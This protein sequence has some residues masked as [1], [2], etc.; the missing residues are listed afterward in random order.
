METVLINNSY[1]YGRWAHSP[2]APT[3]PLGRKQAGLSRLW[4]QPGGPCQP[5]R[6]R[7]GARAICPF[8]PRRKM[9]TPHQPQS[10]LC[11][12]QD[13]RPSAP[14]PCPPM[15]GATVPGDKRHQQPWVP[16]WTWDLGAEAS[17]VPH[18]RSVTSRWG[19]CPTPG[20]L[21]RG[22]PD[23]W[24]PQQQVVS[25]EGAGQD[26]GGCRRVGGANSPGPPCGGRT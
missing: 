5:A 6:G 7:E 19:W 20:P 12:P 2:W 4:A 3:A 18:D 24:E 22:H 9:P 26:R 8:P 17:G 14:L 10:R 15:Q 25:G 21:P 11:P 1:E 13:G 16:S 23:I